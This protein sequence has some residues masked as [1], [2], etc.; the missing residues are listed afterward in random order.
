MVKDLKVTAKVE[1]WQLLQVSYT[2]FV[3]FVECNTI[4]VSACYVTNA[5]HR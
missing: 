4:D 2:R 3:Y 1:C 5:S